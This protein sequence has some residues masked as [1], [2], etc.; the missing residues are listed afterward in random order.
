[1]ASEKQTHVEVHV[2]TN[3]I[4]S[5]CKLYVNHSNACQQHNALNYCVCVCVC[6]MSIEQTI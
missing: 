5:L 1:M 6:C 4:L 2:Y 3:L